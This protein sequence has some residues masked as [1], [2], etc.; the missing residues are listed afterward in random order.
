MPS[1]GQAFLLNPAGKKR[2]KE[3]SYIVSTTVSGDLAKWL[4]KQ[5]QLQRTTLADVVRRAL[6]RERLRV[7]A[8]LARGTT[9]DMLNF[10]LD[11]G[12]I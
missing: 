2:G 8:E 11:D 9:V 4:A 12:P 6:V 5:T 3:P 10:D 1:V 7:E